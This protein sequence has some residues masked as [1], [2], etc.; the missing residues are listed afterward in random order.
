MKV[1]GN[2]EA[3]G[4]VEGAWGPY[5]MSVARQWVVVRDRGGNLACLTPGWPSF[6]SSRIF[7]SC[8]SLSFGHNT[9]RLPPPGAGTTFITR[10]KIRGK[11]I[12][13]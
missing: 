1:G 12:Y 3:Q 11:Y 2:K 6:Q 4:E 7:S 10:T 5:L 13:L 9:S 8:Q